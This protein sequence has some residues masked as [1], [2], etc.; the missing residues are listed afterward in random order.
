MEKI[1]FTEKAQKAFDSFDYEIDRQ[2]DGLFTVHY[3]DG[4]TIADDLTENDLNKFFEE[5]LDD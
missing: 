1:N 5:L 2:E 4:M 3:H